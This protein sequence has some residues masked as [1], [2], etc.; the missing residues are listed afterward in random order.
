[1]ATPICQACAHL[2]PGPGGEG[3]ACTAF[4]GGIPAAIYSGG[5]DHREG[6]PGD[7][8]IRFEL[9]TEPGA[10]VRLDAYEWSVATEGTE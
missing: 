5:F 1:M 7:G 6:Y 2:G 3:V 4:P 9:S 8:G 10:E